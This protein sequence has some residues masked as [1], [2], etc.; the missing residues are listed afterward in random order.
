MSAFTDIW[1]NIHGILTTSDYITLG[2]IAVV[3]IG[4]AF[5][6][7]GLAALVTSTFIALVAFAVVV[8]VRA[9]IAGGSKTDVATL[10]QTDWH[11]FMGWQVQMLLAYAIIFA[12]L[13]AVVSTV[14]NLVL[15]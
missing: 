1:N 7:E 10:V 6:T 12:V 2:I 4:A 3:A 14:R 5:I 8:L 13:I 15:R 11:S 9:A